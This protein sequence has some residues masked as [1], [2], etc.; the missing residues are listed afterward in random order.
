MADLKADPVA[1]QMELL[2]CPGGW[3]L[4]ALCL[5]EM[6]DYWVVLKAGLRAGCLA[7]KMAAYWVA[8]VT[9]LRAGCLAELMDGY[10]VA[11]VSVWQS[12]VVPHKS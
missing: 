6:A 2:V 11:L 12:Q 3:L 7:G 10:W 5:T 9:V 1:F 8:L 4:G